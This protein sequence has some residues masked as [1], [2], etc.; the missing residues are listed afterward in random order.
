MG[1]MGDY[2]IGRTGYDGAVKSV[3]GVPEMRRGLGKNFC[4]GV[5]FVKTARR[6]AKSY[7]C[8]RTTNRGFLMSYKVR[9]KPS[10]CRGTRVPI[11][12]KR[13][14][15]ILLARTRVSRSNGLPTVCTGKFEKPMC[16][17]ST[18]DRLYSVVLESD[19]RVRVFRTR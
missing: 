16:T 17:A 4:V 2:Q 13:V 11:T 7:C 8:L 19:T 9:R 12:L 3:G 15:F 1:T 10:C 6:I 5:A 18:A 14:R